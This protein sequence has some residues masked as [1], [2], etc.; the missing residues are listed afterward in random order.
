PTF[1]TYLRHIYQFALTIFDRFIA[2]EGMQESRIAMERVNVENFH[3]IT[4]TGGI[5][6]LS[7][8]GNWAQ[9]FKIFETFD[10][11]LNI[12]MAEE[13]SDELSAL[14]SLASTNKRIKI[15]DM[16]AGMQTA[17]EIAGALM[18]KEVVIM[19]ADRIVNEKK[20]LDIPFLGAPA[21]FNSGPFEVAAMR[22]A[23]MV[24]LCIVRSGDESLKIIISDIIE[25]QKDQDITLPM[26]QYVDFLD[27]TVRQYPL[28]WFNFYDFWK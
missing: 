23:P 4:Q 16:N 5:V 18:R 2:K 17:V 14:E 7:H 6:V 1:G 24:G 3:S 25:N 12:V 26:Q 20:V 10:V 22:N 11:T 13:V 19:M 28:Q 27:K 9:S 15:I 8:L 21:P